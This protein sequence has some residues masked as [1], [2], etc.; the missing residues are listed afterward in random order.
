M[1]TQRRE[2]RK[3]HR[4]SFEQDVTL[5][6]EGQSCSVKVQDLSLNGARVAFRGPA[7]PAIGTQV[8]LYIPLTGR[9]EI[10]MTA[11]VVHHDRNTLGLERVAIDL[12]SIS[13]LRR[14]VANKLSDPGLLARDLAALEQ[15]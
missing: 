3:F 7:P 9:Q 4:V 6:W 11:R 1:S 15:S 8:T 12:D 14:V 13:H 5:R 10:T 2:Q